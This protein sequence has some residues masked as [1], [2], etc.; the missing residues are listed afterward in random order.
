MEQL[1]EIADQ[2]RLGRE[3]AE[4]Q[5]KLMST[6]M[7]TSLDSYRK[8]LDDILERNKAESEENKKMLEE[9]IEQL[10]KQVC[11]TGAFCI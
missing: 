9:E 4:K 2:Q 5:I 11:L 7:M 8:G 6:Q 1:K 10:R 3:A